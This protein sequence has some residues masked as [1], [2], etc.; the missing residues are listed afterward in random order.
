M[1]AHKAHLSHRVKGTEY[2]TPR[3]VLDALGAFDLDPCASREQ[4]WPTAAHHYT[5]DDDG[6]SKEW[7]GRVWCNPPFGPLSDPWL[8]RMAHHGNGIALIPAAVETE[9]FYRYV[10]PR[11]TAICFLRGRPYFHLPG[12]GDRASHNAGCSICLIAF[13]DANAVALASS[14]L[15]VTLPVTPSWRDW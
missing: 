9:R 7:W 1:P 3:H 14:G 6:L 13:D 10:W 4:P 5:E 15:G 8:D 11:A 12:S 2:I